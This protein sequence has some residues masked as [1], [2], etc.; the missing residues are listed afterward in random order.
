MP[1][2][3]KLIEQLAEHGNLSKACRDLG[4]VRT[5]FLLACDNDPALAD[6]Y[7]RAKKHGI[8]RTMEELLDSPIEDA[9]KDRLDWDRKRWHASKL[10]PKQYGD[11]QLIG[12][13][14]DNPLPSSKLDL[15][16]LSAEV[17]EALAKAG[18]K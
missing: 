8:D 15:S 1:D 2:Y 12:S 17:L 16:G 7:A 6:K 11:K 18:V 13:D 4:L 5:T 9:A 3:T 10:F 14:P